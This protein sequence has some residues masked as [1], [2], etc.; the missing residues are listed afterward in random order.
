MTIFGSALPVQT[1]SQM[2]SWEKDS[3][4]LVK[5]KADVGTKSVL[6]LSGKQFFQSNYGESLFVITSIASD[7]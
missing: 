2:S 6:I 3:P 5:T 7:E 4:S 1:L